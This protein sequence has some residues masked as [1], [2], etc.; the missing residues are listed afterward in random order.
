[1]TTKTLSLTHLVQEP[2]TP[3][4][5]GTKPPLL[6]LLHGVRSNEQDLMGLASYLDPR[7]LLL[8]TRAPLTLGPG[9]YGWYPVQFTPTG[10]IADEEVAA[11][12][13]ETLTRFL[14]EA[15]EAYDADPKRVYLMGFSQGAIMSLYT[16]L[17][18][19]DLVAGIAPMSGR[20]LKRAWEERANDDALR[21]LPILAVHGVYDNV[22]PI[23]EGRTIREA[24]SQ[25]PVAL[26]YQ[27][28]SMGHEVSPE[29]LRDVTG[30]LTR[31]LDGTGTADR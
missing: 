10:L 1:M 11:T 30:F 29:S 21:G 18:R 12:S 28:Y 31:L 8:S 4:P 16:A 23:S 7:F 20:L 17:T 9:A 3:A 19:P 13:K 22:L 25:L 2:R 24:L 26:T 14:A 5:E 15:V 6:V 27:E